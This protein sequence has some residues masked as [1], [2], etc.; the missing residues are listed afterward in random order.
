MHRVA[1]ATR[2]LPE[3]TYPPAD[4][5]HAVLAAC[6][7]VTS[8][9]KASSMLAA[10]GIDPEFVDDADLVRVLPPDASLPR[11]ASFRGAPWTR[12]G[13]R[14]VLPMFDSDGAVR[15]VRAWRVGDGETPKRLPP[16]GYRASSLVLADAFGVATLRGTYTPRRVI[17]LEGESDFLA[18]TIGWRHVLAA[19][20]GIVS[21]SW[22]DE[23]AA[24]IPDST[25][26]AIWTDDDAPGNKYA[27][28]IAATLET[29]CTIRRAGKDVRHERAA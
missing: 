14:L 15:S 29:R 13:H 7:R 27:E 6:I 11:W 20:I 24:R 21:G 5:V 12:T 4:E 2:L 22:S 19:R 3:R 26:V 1:R 8:D 17:I 9:A 18:A 23:I 25:E 16:A 28:C 10:R